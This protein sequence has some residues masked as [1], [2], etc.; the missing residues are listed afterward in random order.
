MQMDIKVEETYSANNQKQ[1]ISVGGNAMMTSVVGDQGAF[2]KQGSNKMDLPKVIYDDLKKSLGVVPEI[3]LLASGEAVLEGI[4]NVNDTEVYVVK[5]P[6]VGVSYTNYYSKE[7]GLKIKESTM[8]NFNGQMQTNNTDYP[9][10][11]E[12]SGLVLPSEKSFNL[13]GQE[14]SLTLEEAVVNPN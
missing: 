12:I 1:V 5:V 14:I 6:G 13:G 2:M 8:V 11:K 7:T 3:G 9:N 10:Y 4:E